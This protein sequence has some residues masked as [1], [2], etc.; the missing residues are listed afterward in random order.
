MVGFNLGASLYM[1]TDHPDT[2]GARL[3]DFAD[4]FLWGNLR[5]FVCESN[6]TDISNF[7]PNEYMTGNLTRLSE[8]RIQVSVDLLSDFIS[9]F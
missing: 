4:R 7:E 9:S 3:D 8:C 2:V 6:A 1:P 5:Y